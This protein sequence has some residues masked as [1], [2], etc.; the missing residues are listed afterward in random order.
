MLLAIS[1]LGPDWSDYVM[2]LYYEFEP[3]HLKMWIWRSNVSAAKIWSES[4]YIWQAP[5]RTEKTGVTTVRDT[6]LGNTVLNKKCMYVWVRRDSPFQSWGIFSSSPSSLDLPPES[7]RTTGLLLFFHS[8]IYSFSLLFLMFIR[9]W[10][11]IIKEHCGV[12]WNC[13][14]NN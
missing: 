8:F 5:G 10:I 3:G 12:Y 1:R 11:R 6:D 14:N 9:L 7:N 4:E 13:K 2:T